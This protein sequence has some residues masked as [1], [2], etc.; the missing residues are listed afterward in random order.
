MSTPPP[1]KISRAPNLPLVWIVPLV[2]L[3]VGGWMVFRE[4]RHRGPEITIEF[5][6]G[7][8]IEARQTTVEYKGVSIGVVTAV[9]LKPDLTA[10][11]VAVRL[12]QNAAAVAGE[13]ARFWIV[14]PEI[15]FSGVRGLDTLLT[16]ARINVLPGGGPPALA[17]RGLEKAPPL[18]SPAE[19]RAF[20]LQGDRLGSLSPGSPVFYREVKVGLVET[21]RLADDSTSVLVR[22]RIHTP[23]VDLVRTTTRFWNAGGLS[24]NVSLL[25][26]RMKSTSLESLFAGGVA[27]ATPDKDLGP[28]AA[29][30]AVF[31]LHSEFEKDWVKWQP[32]IPIQPPD[33]SPEAKR[34]SMLESVGDAVIGSAPTTGA[35]EGVRR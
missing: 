12:N 23:Y 3:A 2:A 7:A 16:G 5:T 21:S 27:F 33:E 20:L 4:F 17:F 8:G 18:E 31:L 24:F 15:G 1:P 14:Q 28:P 35:A 19:G 6:D 10:V 25:G 9:D 13:G 34:S 29:E 26:A 30:G 11:L 22:I 32:R